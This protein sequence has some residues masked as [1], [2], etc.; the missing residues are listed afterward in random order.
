MPGTRR[1][2]GRALSGFSVLQ[3]RVWELK[4]TSVEV[5]LISNIT[6]FTLRITCGFR[7]R[8]SIQYATLWQARS[9]LS[10]ISVVPIELGAN[11]RLS[12]TNGDFGAPVRHA[13]I[14][15]KVE[16]EN[17]KGL[18]CLP[19][20]NN[21]PRACLLAMVRKCRARRDCR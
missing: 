3:I 1:I 7:K 18:N 2:N 20:T 10:H 15:R 16:R 12:W 5:N 8:L 13:I 6:V 19:S 17:E 4:S 11:A 14:L 9:L 21:S